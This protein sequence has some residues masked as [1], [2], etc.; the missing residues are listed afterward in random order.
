MFVLENLKI[1]KLEYFDTH[2]HYDHRRF[3]CGRHELIA[4]MHENGLKYA[5]NAAI[6]FETNKAMQKELSK[7]EWIYFAHGIH[8]RAVTMSDEN[9]NKYEACLREM[10]KSDRAVAV[11]ETGLDYH[12]LEQL[13]ASENS[14]TDNLVIDED[15]VKTR[16]KL[17]FHKSIRLAMQAKLPLILHIR[18]SHEDAL[19]ILEQYSFADRAGVVHC[20]T[21]DYDFARRYADMG[22]VI[23]IGGKVTYEQE[24]ELREVVKSLPL[25]KIVLETDSPFVLP[26]GAAGSRNNSNNLLLIAKEIAEIKNISLNEVL[27][28]TMENGKKLFG[29]KGYN[30]SYEENAR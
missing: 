14:V 27:S 20:F 12:N 3:D 11:G 13:I 6:S 7:Y 9:D 24:Q 19:E 25:D 29:I 28:V 4:Q 2:T 17:W 8:P 30:D 15:L 10:L 5:V 21:G 16:Q 22:F 1:E 26:V 18:D 23:G